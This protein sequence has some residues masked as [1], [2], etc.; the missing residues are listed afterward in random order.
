MNTVQRILDRKMTRSIKQI[1]NNWITRK[2][3]PVLN[4]TRNYEEK[5]LMINYL[6]SFSV[7]D[8]NRTKTLIPITYTTDS[9]ENYGNDL[10]ICFDCKFLM[11]MH[12]YTAKFNTS[13]W[14]IFNVQQTG[15]Y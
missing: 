6:P 3:Y 9:S 1:M 12:S 15:K 4:V 2:Y 7:F 10:N 8:N 5:T 13:E 14:V 11:L